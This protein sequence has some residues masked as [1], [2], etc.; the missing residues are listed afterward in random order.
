MISAP[1]MR[2]S[3]YHLEPHFAICRCCQIDTVLTLTL[4]SFLTFQKCTSN[5]PH[6]PYHNGQLTCL[7]KH[8]N[9]TSQLPTSPH[10]LPPH[11]LA[12]LAITLSNTSEDLA[13]WH[14]PTLGNPLIQEKNDMKGEPRTTMHEDTGEG[15][16]HCSPRLFPWESSRQILLPR[17]YAIQWE[18]W[19]LVINDQFP[20]PLFP[21]TSSFPSFFSF[22]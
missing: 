6:H 1:K 3:V 14:P 17:W 9:P 13:L 22:I 18:R 12:S 19:R 16:K 10:A 5:D 15:T 2:R 4:S 11:N 21:L 7:V 8:S 20:C